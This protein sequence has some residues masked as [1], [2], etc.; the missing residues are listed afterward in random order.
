MRKLLPGEVEDRIGK[1]L[2][3]IRGHEVQRYAPPAL[4]PRVA[5]EAVWAPAPALPEFVDFA[6]TCNVEGTPYASRCQLVN[7]VYRY[8]G[9]V[10]A[11]EL[12]ARTLY[13]SHMKLEEV[14][15]LRN[16]RGLPLLRIRG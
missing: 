10:A 16:L 14:G 1:A 2:S 12:A 5:E 6:R 7:G 8:S 13:R 4:Q 9:P 15:G 11:D 3:L